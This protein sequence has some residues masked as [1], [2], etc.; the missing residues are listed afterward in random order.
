[1]LL[2]IEF[3]MGCLLKLDLLRFAKW[4]DNTFLTKTF[5]EYVKSEISIS[6][7]K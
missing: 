1:M 5:A 4:V 3:F 6:P 2:L 7:H